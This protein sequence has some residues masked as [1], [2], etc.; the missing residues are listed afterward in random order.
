MHTMLKSLQGD[1]HSVKKSIRG[2]TSDK[3]FIRFIRYLL[4]VSDVCHVALQSL[5]K[6]CWKVGIKLWQ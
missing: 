4:L 5:Y 1:V 6:M 2:C 3:K